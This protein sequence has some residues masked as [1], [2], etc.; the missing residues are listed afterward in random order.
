MLRSLTIGYARERAARFF[1]PL[2]DSD[3]HAVRQLVGCWLGFTAGA[4]RDR[5]VGMRSQ[6]TEPVHLQFHRE[7]YGLSRQT[8]KI[9]EYG[10]EP[11]RRFIDIEYR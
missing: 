6:Q 5:T 7:S 9:A 3:V 4:A 8:E 2:P 10:C 1:E 11:Q